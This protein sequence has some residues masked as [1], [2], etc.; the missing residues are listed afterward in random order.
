MPPSGTNTRT[1]IGGKLEHQE[2]QEAANRSRATKASASGDISI[3][4]GCFRCA[5]P[6]IVPRP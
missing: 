5:H 2:P 3:P 6:Q 4:A 1:L